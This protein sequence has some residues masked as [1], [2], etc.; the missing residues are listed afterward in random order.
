MLTCPRLLS[1]NRELNYQTSI[2]LCSKYR[3]ISINRCF[4][5]NHST[6]L[7]YSPHFNFRCI[8]EYAEYTLLSTTVISRFQFLYILGF[9]ILDLSGASRLRAQFLHTTTLATSL[10]Q[11]T[12]WA[13]T[14]ACLQCSLTLRGKTPPTLTS[15]S[16]ISS[17]SATTLSAISLPE[18]ANHF[19]PPHAPYSLMRLCSPQAVHL[20]AAALS[21]CLHCCAA[22]QPQDLLSN[23]C[24]P[25]QHPDFSVI[26]LLLAA[27]SN[28][29]FCCLYFLLPAACCLSPI[30]PRPAVL[31][32]QGLVDG[33]DG[34]VTL[35]H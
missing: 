26:H 12:P 16:A 28:C 9:R 29:T 20:P 5:K 11:F 2:C 13:Q 10:L 18:P 19:L 24:A 27:A 32:V 25:T 8:A 33:E 15:I 22:T 34:L 21:D 1:S 23:P 31:V 6:T 17:T 3:N 35:K 14:R 4:S 30:A 7:Y